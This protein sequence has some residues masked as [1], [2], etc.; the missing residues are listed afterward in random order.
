LIEGVRQ[1]EI[2]DLPI[3]Y[4]VIDPGVAAVA[5]IG[6]LEVLYSIHDWDADTSRGV[7]P[8]RRIGC[9]YNPHTPNQAGRIAKTQVEGIGSWR[10]WG[11][12]W[13]NDFIGDALDKIHLCAIA[14]LDRARNGWIE[15]QRLPA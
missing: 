10:G 5:G 13:G 7:A 6:Q 4:G 15:V 14:E 1:V 11:R 8:R 3:R 2:I 9:P 12:G